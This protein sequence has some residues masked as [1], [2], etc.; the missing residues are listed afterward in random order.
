MS[1]HYLFFVGKADTIEVAQGIRKAGDNCLSLRVNAAVE[2]GYTL[3][4]SGSLHRFEQD[5][6]P[7]YAV[8]VKVED[9]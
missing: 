4:S 1:E 7:L 3:V 6:L 5:G 2:R 8:M 9:D